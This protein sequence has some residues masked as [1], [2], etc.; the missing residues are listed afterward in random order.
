MI[1]A[2]KLVGWGLAMM[3]ACE[4]DADGAANP[5]LALGLALGAATRAGRDKMTLILPPALEPFGLWVELDV[6]VNHF[7]VN[8]MDALRRAT[9]LAAEVMGVAADYG[10]VE[11]GKYADIIVVRGDPLRHIDVLRDPVV[12]IKHGK[13]VK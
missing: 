8:A 7:G 6:W 3:D 11:R 9:S 13:R 12:V 2:G 10:T 1:D 4:R 5:G